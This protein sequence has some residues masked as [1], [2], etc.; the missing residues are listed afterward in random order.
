M[1]D[2]IDEIEEQMELD[3][4]ISQM[5]GSPGQFHNIDYN[6]A[7]DFEP[8]QTPQHL[9]DHAALRGSLT[10]AGTGL[11]EDLPDEDV[12]KY[13]AGTVKTTVTVF[14]TM[15]GP[16]MLFLPAGV[17]NAGLLTA[18]CILLFVGV[19]VMRCIVLLLNCERMLAAEGKR[20]LG[21][22]DVGFHVYGKMGRNLVDAAIIICQMG[23]CTMYCVFI[24]ENLQSALFEISKCDLH[25]IFSSEY[26]VYYIILAVMPLVIP[27]TWIRQLK[28]FALTNFLAN[29]IVIV[30]FFYMFSS[31]ITNFEHGAGAKGEVENFRLGGSLAFFGTSMYMFESGTVMAIPVQRSMRNPEKLPTLLIGIT[32]LVIA[33]QMAFSFS[34][35]W[36]FGDKTQSI[37]TL[38]YADGGDTPAIGGMIPVEIVQISWCVCVFFTFPL[39][40]FPAAKIIEKFWFSDRRSGAKCQKNLIRAGMVAICMTISIGGYSSVDNLVSLVGAVGCV[41]LSVIFP[42]LFH[43]KL[44]TSAGSGHPDE[45]KSITADV[46]I[47]VFGVIGLMVAVIMAT[48][49][50]INSTF[51]PVV[52]HVLNTT[53]TGS[54][55][56]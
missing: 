23:F 18:M 12:S 14:K 33:I 8:A 40:I 24:A 38:S 34:C 16:G 55:Y 28:Y 44:C 2:T 7:S 4:E 20:C 45:G 53:V 37:V 47:F 3:D 56:L 1:A 46:F 35:V 30:S 43:W 27:F 32:I 42:A 31:N 5:A 17:K 29:L 26:L 49:K 19:V 9:S 41:P 13:L 54:V 48:Y 52:C 36:V 10:L 15:V 25:G 21:F 50:W 22:G 11:K 39:M 51:E 6:P